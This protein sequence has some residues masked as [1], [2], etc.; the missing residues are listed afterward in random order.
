M[1]QSPE[2]QRTFPYCNIQETP[3]G[4]S[5]F[6]LVINYNEKFQTAEPMES[7]E[8]ARVRAEE[9]QRIWDSY[10]KRPFLGST[11]PFGAAAQSSAEED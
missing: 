4:V 10:R 5:A 9:W 7:L 2:Q 8:E 6:L 3:A 1:P 11:R